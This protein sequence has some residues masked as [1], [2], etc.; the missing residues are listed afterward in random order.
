MP[1]LEDVVVVLLRVLNLLRR[2]CGRWREATRGDKCAWAG[3]QRSK[4]ELTGMGWDGQEGRED[5]KE[6]AGAEWCLLD[7]GREVKQ[8]SAVRKRGRA[9]I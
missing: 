4:D 7:L 5:D 8:R 1:V 9:Q 3:G 6:E 2:H